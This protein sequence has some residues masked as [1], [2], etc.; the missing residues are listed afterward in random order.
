MLSKRPSARPTYEALEAELAD[1]EEAESSLNPDSPAAIG[2]SVRPLARAS[3]RPG[4]QQRVLC[5]V[6]V[7]RSERAPSDYAAE[8]E[9]QFEIFGGLGQRMLDGSRIITFEHHRGA[10]EQAVAAAQCAFALHQL[11]PDAALALCTGRA[12]LDGRLP[13][14]E[15]FERAATFLGETPKGR[16]RVD[17]AS[18]GLLDARFTIH[19]TRAGS[20]LQ[21]ERDGGE[22]PRTLLGTVT[23]FV[24]RSRELTQ[25]ELIY[26]ECVN[27]R[28]ANAVLVTGAAGAGKSRL[29]HELVQR[30]LGHG[31]EFRLVVARGDSVREKMPFGALGPAIRTWCGIGSGDSADAKRAKVLRHM[32]NAVASQVVA[33]TAGFIGEMI[34]VPFPDDHSSELRAARRDP[35]LMADQMLE[36]WLSWLEAECDRAPVVF[37]VEDLHWADP[38]SVRYLEAALRT[39]GSRPLL[40]VAFARPQVQEVYPNLWADRATLEMRLPKLGPRSCEQLLNAIGGSLTAEMRTWVTDR[41]DG[42]PFFLEELV[43]GLEHHTHSGQLP[44]T[45]LGV[46]QARLD[47]LSE[48]A[49]LVIRAGSVFG[50]AFRFDAVRALVGPY[51]SVDVAGALRQLTDREIVFHRGALGD[52]EYVFRHALIR[53]VAYALLLDDE[54]TLGHRLAGEWLEAQP[55]TEPA[56][57]ASHFEKGA[58][59]ERA[60]H[61]YGRAA[62]DALE[63]GALEEVV[64]CGERAMVCGAA[65]DALGEISA[66]VAEAISYSGGADSDAAQ[67]AEAALERLPT[68]AA[69][70]WRASQILAIS[71]LRQALPQADQIIARIL[72]NAEVGTSSPEQAIALS[73]VASDSFRVARGR[74][75]SSPP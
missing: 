3:L 52:Q 72:A 2:G 31:E 74:S 11:L 56:I 54:R 59:P 23:P 37:I 63:A 4:V 49:K 5:A 43:R 14:G 40:V 35:Q 41:A 8:L 29:R 58:V 20:Y 51:A 18:T 64:R 7:G 66:L 30:L 44:D 62:T 53:D 50:H 19:S 21:G 17:D 9:R 33:R 45:V 57:L 42:N 12:V 60:V 16:I 26:H 69:A 73:F 71:A 1:I 6:F 28:V 68:S 61:W 13:F 65:S 38:A 32:A 10:T 67:W 55:V 22:A 70:W 25:L 39:L 75:R 36:N 24:G 48:H 15:I 34:G 46:V 27:E 47:A